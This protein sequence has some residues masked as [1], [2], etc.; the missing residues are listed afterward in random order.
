MAVTRGVQCG[1]D[2]RNVYERLIGEYIGGLQQIA[3]FPIETN[4]MLQ[5][6]TNLLEQLFVIHCG[7]ARP[8]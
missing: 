7:E 2:R 3:L 6:L 4:L 8:T 5:F 1:K